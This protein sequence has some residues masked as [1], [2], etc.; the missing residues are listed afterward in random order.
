MGMPGAA[1]LGPSGWAWRGRLAAIARPAE[2]A[3]R[4]DIIGVGDLPGG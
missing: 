3:R 2:I 4:K 1:F